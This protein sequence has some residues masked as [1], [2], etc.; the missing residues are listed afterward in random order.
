MIQNP[1]TRKLRQELKAAQ[2]SSLYWYQQAT[3]HQLEKLDAIAQLRALQAKQPKRGKG[4][5]FEK[6]KK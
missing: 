2:E 5:K 4:G 3:K 1:F 6:V